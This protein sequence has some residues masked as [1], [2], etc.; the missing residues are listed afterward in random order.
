MFR[1]P[2]LLLAGLLTLASVS[3]Y[4]QM[5]G[6]GGPGGPQQPP[7]PPTAGAKL[8]I[9]PDGSSATY[10]VT[11]QFVG[12]AFSNEAVGTTTGVT[13]SITIKADGT[14]AP[15][16]KL[17]V[18]LKGLKSDQ[19]Q[20]DGFVQNRTLETAKFPTAEFVPTK[21]SGLDKMIPSTGQTGIALTGNLTIHGVTKEVTFQGIATFNPRESIVAGRAKT[22]LTFDQFGIA[23]P[24]IGR[25]ASV[26]NK[27]ELELVYRFKRSMP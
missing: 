22:T 20:R 9:V 16:S 2:T 14:I 11:E 8:D 23:P 26:D 12:V 3:A 5:P 6:P 15:G 17:T 4:A 24:K 21:V 1:K 10:R 27:I 18:D 7:P 13:G 19:D 25:L